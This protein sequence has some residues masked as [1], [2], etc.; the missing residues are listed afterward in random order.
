LARIKVRLF[1]DLIPISNKSEVDVEAGDLKGL[2]A[3]LS[4]EMG[5]SFR[6]PLYDSHGDPRPYSLIYHN[7]KAYRLK[8]VSNF[9]LKDGDVVLFVPPVGGG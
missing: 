8:D 6:Q 3:F 5:E 4:G 7:G 2:L 1:Y 9:G